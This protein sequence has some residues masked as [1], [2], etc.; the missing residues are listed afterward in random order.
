MAVVVKTF[1]Q[2][3]HDLLFVECCDQVVEFWRLFE[4]YRDRQREI[5]SGFSMERRGFYAKGVDYREFLESFSDLT[6]EECR[7]LSYVITL[8]GAAGRCLRTLNYGALI[9][10][11]GRMRHQGIFFMVLLLHGMLIRFDLREK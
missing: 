8:E 9:K 4:N 10:K 2:V 6:F 3:M 1:D 5:G 7:R 11:H